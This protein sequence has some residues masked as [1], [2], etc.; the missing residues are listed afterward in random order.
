MDGILLARGESL[1]KGV[2]IDGSTLM[3]ITPT[4]LYLMGCKIPEDMDG[5]VLK[6]IFKETF[7][8]EHTVEFTEPAE[9]TQKERGEMS[10]DEEKKV[11]ERLRNLGYID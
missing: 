3:D 10:P 6:G 1:K 2:S 9:D 5:K 4:V 7:L 11:L 8:E